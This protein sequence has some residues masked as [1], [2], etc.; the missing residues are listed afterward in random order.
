MSDLETQVAELQAQV[1]ALL[2]LQP[3]PREIDPGWT[4]RTCQVCGASARVIDL[5]R[6]DSILP[7][8]WNGEGY[9]EEHADELGVTADDHP[10][11]R[12]PGPKP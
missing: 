2:A 11:L 6:P 5:Q 4:V 12:K 1:A 9:C 3:P 10:H 8:Y 7:Q